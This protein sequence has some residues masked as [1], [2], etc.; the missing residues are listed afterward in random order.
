MTVYQE[1]IFYIII[2]FGKESAASEIHN[3]LR[4]FMDGNDYDYFSINEKYIIVEG[5][6]CKDAASIFECELNLVI[7]EVKEKHVATNNK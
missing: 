1:N 2:R 5:F 7:D 3:A 4:K 6:D